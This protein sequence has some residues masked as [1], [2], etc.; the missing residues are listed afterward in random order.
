MNVPPIDRSPGF[1]RRSDLAQQNLADYIGEFNFRLQHL[2]INLSSNFP[3]TTV[4][5][6][7]TNWLFTLAIKN[8][9]FFAE[10]SALQDS[11]SFCSLYEQYGISRLRLF[12]F[13]L[14]DV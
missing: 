11:T 4:F 8:P 1:T 13:V 14:T 7:D 2:A 6:F 3:D 10:T 5:Q 12:F 9:D